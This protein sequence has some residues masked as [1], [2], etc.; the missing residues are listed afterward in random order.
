M[1]SK[2]VKQQAKTTRVRWSQ[3]EE[4]KMSWLR[5]RGLKWRQVAK[6]VTNRIYGACFIHAW[7]NKQTFLV[8][9]QWSPVED[10]VLKQLKESSLPWKEI[11]A[12][13]P[14]RSLEGCQ[15]RWHQHLK[16]GRSNRDSWTADEDTLLKSLK[17]R[18]K[19]SWA[20]IAKQLLRHDTKSCQN[21]YYKY[22][23]NGATGRYQ[24][25]GVKKAWTL[26]KDTQLKTLKECGFSWEE[27]AENFPE[28]N[29][30]SCQDRYYHHLVDGAKRPQHGDD[31]VE[32][33]NEFMEGRDMP[34]EQ[35]DG[36]LEDVEESLEIR[37]GLVEDRDDVE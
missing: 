10:A 12:Q 25:R 15:M 9:S 24:N 20:D 16:T 31:S 19:M 35:G 26:K 29:K 23:K 37:D 17:T 11:A 18:T 4:D 2:P 21:R 13:L 6:L 34:L 32:D 30:L 28:Q 5:Q 36:F 8:K 33:K 14:N 7:K 1:Q 3:E 22:L 27:I